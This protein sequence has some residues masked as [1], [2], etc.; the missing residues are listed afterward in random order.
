M[1]RV[2][3]VGGRVYMV[4]ENLDHNLT[5]FM[6]EKKRTENR[7]LLESEIKIIMK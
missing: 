2:E 3:L 7:N 4:F 1:K 5:D 6:R